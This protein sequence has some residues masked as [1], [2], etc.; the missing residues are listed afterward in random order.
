M[1]DFRGRRK[2][3]RVEEE[4]GI[5]SMVLLEGGERGGG[6]GVIGGVLRVKCRI[7]RWNWFS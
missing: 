2:R 6:G 1:G 7:L 3:D 4:E 5:R